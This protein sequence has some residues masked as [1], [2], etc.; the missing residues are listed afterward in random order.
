MPMTQKEKNAQTDEI[1][2]RLIVITSEYLMLDPSN[3]DHVSNAR[4]AMTNIMTAL[5]FAYAKM[6]TGAQFLQDTPPNT[7][8]QNVIAVHNEACTLYFTEYNQFEGEELRTMH[9]K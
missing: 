8:L 7:F 5:T 4:D 6:L 3:E 2:D 9:G 1:Y